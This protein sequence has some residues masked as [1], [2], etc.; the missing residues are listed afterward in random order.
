LQQEF[1]LTYIFISHSLPVV[2]QVA[3]RVAVMRAGKFVETGTVEQVLR[4]P[5]HAYTRELLAACDKT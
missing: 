1:G 4:R 2:A 5:A 3:T